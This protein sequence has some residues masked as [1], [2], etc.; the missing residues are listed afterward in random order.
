MG[1]VFEEGA[2]LQKREARIGADKVGPKRHRRDKDKPDHQRRRGYLRE[3][4]FKDAPVAPAD[5]GHIAAQPEH[6]ADHRPDRQPPEHGVVEPQKALEPRRQFLPL[7][8]IHVIALGIVVGIGQQRIVVVGKVGILEPQVGHAK[9]ERGENQR[10]IPEGAFERVAVDHLMRQ[11]GMLG[12]GDR[13]QRHRQPEAHLRQYEHGN[14][15]ERIG[16]R[17]QRNRRPFRQQVLIFH[18]LSRGAC[19]GA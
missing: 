15:P 11:R 19:P 5:R 7:A 8:R 14:R 6:M 10:G 12:G 18:G 1:A 9:V 16:G 3:P 4:A 17:K 2:D 13:H